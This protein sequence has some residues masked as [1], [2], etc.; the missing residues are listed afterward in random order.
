MVIEATR[1]KGVTVRDSTGMTLAKVD[2]L[3]FRADQARLVGF[4]VAR[5]GLVKKFAGLDFEDVLSLSAEAV[6]VDSSQTV[7][8]DLAPFDAA[9]RATGPI[10]GVKAKTESGQAI[11]VVGDVVIEAETGGIVRFYLRNFLTERI[12]PLKF[13]VSI[14]PKEIIFKDVVNQPIFDQVASSPEA[15]GA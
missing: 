1:L 4:Q 6:L 12:I 2:H 11:G 15:A 8:S 7:V 3:V 5:S 10:L 9:N 14:S 13:L